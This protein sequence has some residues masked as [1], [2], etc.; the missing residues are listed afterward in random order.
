MRQMTGIDFFAHHSPFGAHASFTLGRIGRGGGFGLEG[1]GPADQDV[2]IGYGRKGEPFRALPFYSGWEQSTAAY[3]GTDDRKDRSGFSRWR[4]FQEGD[5]TRTYNWATDTWTA[6]EMTFTLLTPFGPVADP[7]SKAAGD[8]RDA[9]LP[10]ILAELTIDNRTSGTP[11]WGFVGVGQRLG[12]LRP[13]ADS[14]RGMLEGV[15]HDTA[16]GVAAVAG[17]GVGTIQSMAMPDRVADGQADLHRLGGQGGV[18]FT[19]PART[20]A[21]FTLALGFWRDG[22]VTSGLPGRYA[23]TRHFTGLEDALTEALRRAPALKRLAAVRDAELGKS[24]LSAAQRFLLA[25]ATRS[26]HG[27]T[28]W[29][30]R[31][32]T[33]FWLVNEGEYRMLN[34][35]DLTVDHLF[36][37][38]KWHPW[39]VRN[40][41]DLFAD[42]YAYTDQHGLSFTHDMGVANQ[43]SPPGTSSYEKEE[44]AGCFSHMTHEQLVNW[45]LTGAVYA[46]AT[47]D[48]N[49]LD[50]RLPVF[51]RC[52]DSLIN[53]DARD[54]DKRI[55]I[56]QKDSNRVGRTGEEITTY[57]SLDT[58]LGQARK[59]LYLG[60][61]TWAAYL[62]LE[63]IFNTHGDRRR[64]AG[65]RA[66]AGRAAR[67]IAGRFNRKTGFIPAVFEKNNA[68]A[69]IPAVEG[70]VFP[71]VLGMKHAVSRNGPFRNLIIALT[72]HI[73]TVLKPGVCIDEQSGGW[74][75]SSTSENTWQ[76][77]IAISQ[78]VIRHVMKIRYP[79]AAWKAWDA[80]HMTWQTEGGCRDWA[81]TDQIRSTDGGDLGS[82]YYPRGVTAVLWLEE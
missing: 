54:P 69:I 33:P 32:R 7:E 34:T 64:A 42:R 44:I 25:H 22:V 24:K 74:K 56:M 76:S 39:T 41:L 27:S 30:E 60:V 53:R 45:V 13:L 12:P 29:L 78:F 11:A 43:M 66:Q 75:M 31:D 65:A 15:A 52:L 57:D 40:T 17:K 19:V 2:F 23:Y 28:E 1:F 21:T 14:T 47:R 61:K 50:R 16:W 4:A 82:R 26:Y 5:I 38:L 9:T 36:W 63:S 6:G 18:L 72:R 46:H 79:K 73:R 71:W 68:S 51:E 80:A 58:S 67:T 37:E 10:A 59:N 20:K 81:F 49:W 55:G 8:P 3:T 77:K 48:A 70:L 35:F 62:A